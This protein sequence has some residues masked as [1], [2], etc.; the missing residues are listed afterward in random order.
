[1]RKKT[2]PVKERRFRE[3]TIAASIAPRPAL[4]EPLLTI[5][6]VARILQSSRG[7]VYTLLQSGELPSISIRR[8]RRVRGADLDKFIK[9]IWIHRPVIAKG[10]PEIQKAA[11]PVQGRLAKWRREH[12]QH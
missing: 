10:Q 2:S 8:L 12:G 7:F 4:N 1:M 11:E 6:E 9:E 5:A 3:T